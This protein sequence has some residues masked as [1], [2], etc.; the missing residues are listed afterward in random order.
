M[1]LRLCLGAEARA[2][3]YHSD[4]VDITSTNVPQAQGEIGGSPVQYFANLTVF[5][6]NGEILV[7]GEQSSRPIPNLRNIHLLAGVFDLRKR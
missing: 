7:V 3:I 5:R 2:H 1:R 6:Q 4:L